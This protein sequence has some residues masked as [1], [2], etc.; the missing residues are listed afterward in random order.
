[1][2][3]NGI[4]QFSFVLLH[5]Q[6]LLF[7]RVLRN[8]FACKDMACLADAV[9]AVDGLR[10]RGGIPPWIQQEDV[11]GSREIEADTARLQA[12]EKRGN[13]RICLEKSKP[14]NLQL[15]VDDNGI[16]HVPD[17]SDAY[18]CF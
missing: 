9:G 14:A 2:I 12:D 13:V 1:M 18:E 3:K 7:N 11:V 4:G 8:D 5:L 16:Y 6:D 10:L 15:I 17:Q